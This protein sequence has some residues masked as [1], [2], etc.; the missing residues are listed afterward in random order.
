MTILQI[1]VSRFGPFFKSRL[2]NDAI[3]VLLSSSN[4][5]TRT[6]TLRALGKIKNC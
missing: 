5:Q 2:R 4:T 6:Q 3:S 1:I